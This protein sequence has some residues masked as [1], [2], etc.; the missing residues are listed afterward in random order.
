M[1]KAVEELLNQFKRRFG[2]YPKLVQ[3]DDGKEFYNVKVKT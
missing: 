2:N 3:I 1:T